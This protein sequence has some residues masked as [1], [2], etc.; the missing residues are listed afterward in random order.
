MRITNDDS[1]DRIWLEELEDGSMLVVCCD[2]SPLS[3]YEDLKFTGDRKD[4]VDQILSLIVPLPS[5]DLALMGEICDR[6]RSSAKP[7][8]DSEY[9]HPSRVRTAVLI[10]PRTTM[11]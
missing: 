10:P 8:R 6:F 9:P 7:T 1:H 2:Q 5:N 11:D 3:D 4:W